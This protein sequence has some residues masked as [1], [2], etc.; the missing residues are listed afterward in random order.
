MQVSGKQILE[1]EEPSWSCH[2]AACGMVSLLFN[3]R[4]NIYNLTQCI[5]LCM[6]IF[7]LVWR[8]FLGKSKARTEA[9]YWSVLDI[10]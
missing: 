4:P 2:R 10:C 8:S 9:A 7:L 6:L 1:E 5:Y 3:I